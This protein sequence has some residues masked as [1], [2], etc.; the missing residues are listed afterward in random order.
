MSKMGSMVANLLTTLRE[1][2]FAV[3]ERRKILI[4]IGNKPQNT[5]VKVME[6]A[7]HICSTQPK[8]KAMQMILD[9]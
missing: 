5:K 4:H 9:L 2:K 7:I 1:H 6:K 8:E 3:S